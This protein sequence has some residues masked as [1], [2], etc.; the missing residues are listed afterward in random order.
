MPSDARVVYPLH[1][2]AQRSILTRSI[3]SEAQQVLLSEHAE[4][5]RAVMKDVRDGYVLALKHSVAIQK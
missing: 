1:A 3:R 2:D 5:V 4:T